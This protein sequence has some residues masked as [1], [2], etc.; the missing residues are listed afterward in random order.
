MTTATIAVEQRRAARHARVRAALPDH[1]ERRTWD[2]ARIR[3]HQRDRLRALLHHAKARSRFHAE[4]LAG[5]DPA[6]FELGD[7]PALPTMTK[8]EMMAAFDQVLT[9]P[10]L[11]R[12]VVE[13]HL[14]GSAAEATELL[15]EYVV[16]ASGGSSG[17]RGVFVYGAGAIVDYTLGLTRD[18]LARLLSLGPPPPGGVPMAMVA[19]ASPVHVS[20]ALCDLFSGDLLAVT[21]I[22][23]TLPLPEIVARLNRAQPVL[24]QGYPSVVSLLAEERAAG[25]LR[26]APVAVT[27]SSEQFPADARA[28]VAA[29]F[30]VGVVDQF[31]STEG[32]LGSSAP[33]Q[34]AIV[35]ASDL[36]IVE[37]V[38]ARNRPVPPGTPSAKVLVTNLMNPTQPLI[39]YELTDRFVEQPGA[40]EHGHLR[41]TVEGRA[42][43]L[44]GYGDVVV[45]PLVLRSVLV[46]TPEVVEYQVTQTRRG[47]HV[48]VVAPRGVDG[49]ALA[50][51]LAAA[52]G[53]GGVAAAEVTVESVPAIARHPDTGKARRF[54]PR[55]A[56]A[57]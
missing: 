8:A 7:L 56:G 53:G 22:P 11:S 31:G 50:A 51:R 55:P 43:E 35:L 46:D 45:H 14:A 17:E 12:A 2:A 26:I 1:L 32:V 54:I 10:R 52:L 29:A 41:V 24:L 44:L 9:D 36:A 57:P 5:V 15:G 49:P 21:S 3:A 20:R 47:A 40:A 16:L 39:R 33:D 19:A 30:G 34:E 38:D 27:G 6:R 4:R 13:E 23:V 28:R 48:A 42:D 18:G 37:L 25:R